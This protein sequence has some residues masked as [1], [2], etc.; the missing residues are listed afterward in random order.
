MRQAVGSLPVIYP[1]VRRLRALLNS[2]IFEYMRKDNDGDGPE[3]AII[4]SVV[5]YI[6]TITKEERAKLP[7]VRQIQKIII[8]YV[9]ITKEREHTVIDISWIK[10]PGGIAVPDDDE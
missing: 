8:E 9:D 2:D 1:H 4:G 10:H 6:D 5:S 7:Y 3:R